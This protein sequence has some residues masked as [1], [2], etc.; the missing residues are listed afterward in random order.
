M[1]PT[2]SKKPL[3]PVCCRLDRQHD[4]PLRAPGVQPAQ[5]LAADPLAA[6]VPGHGDVHDAR[7]AAKAVGDE[8]ADDGTGRGVAGDQEGRRR[9]APEHEQRE[10]PVGEPGSKASRWMRATG[11]EVAKPRGVITIG[12]WVALWLLHALRRIQ[13]CERTFQGAIVADPDRRPYRF[14]R[15]WNPNRFAVVETGQAEVR[16]SSR[17]RAIG[18]RRR[19]IRAAQKGTW[20]RTTDSA[21]VSD[22]C[23]PHGVAHPCDPDDAHECHPERLPQGMARH[24]RVDSRRPFGRGADHHRQ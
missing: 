5:H 10:P 21:P 18:D 2:C 9:Q 11:A 17:E 13:R 22:G 6:G 1:Y 4:V 7:I 8:V 15:I 14:R 12:G 16:A 3:R 19:V 24:R 23:L 20:P